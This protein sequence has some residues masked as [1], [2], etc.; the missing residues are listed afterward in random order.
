MPQRDTHPG[1]TIWKVIIANAP[2]FTPH[3]RAYICTASSDP[4]WPQALLVVV[5]AQ[6]GDVIASRPE[7][8]GRAG[9]LRELVAASWRRVDSLL[10]HVRCMVGFFGNL[11]G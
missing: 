4:V 5:L 11:Q 10:Q 7:L 9:R 6:Q 2:D 8:A 1:A 3:P